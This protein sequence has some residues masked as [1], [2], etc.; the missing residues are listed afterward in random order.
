MWTSKATTS[1]R[2]VLRLGGG[3]LALL[4]GCLDQR[5]QANGKDPTTSSNTS[6]TSDSSPTSTTTS[7]P[8][9]VSVS[10]VTVVPGIVAPNTP[11]SVAVFGDRDEQFLI[12]NVAP[13]GQPSPASADF[14]LSTDA[15]T[16]APKDIRDIA[17]HGNPFDRT[18]PYEGAGTGYLLYS[19]SNPLETD[20]VSLRWPGG[21]YEFENDVVSAL[22]R[23]PTDFRVGGLDVPE[24]VES[25]TELTLSVTIENTGSVE[26]TFVGALNRS[27]PYVAHTPVKAISID[28]APGES[29][30]WTH[31][32]TP[33][34]DDPEHAGGMQY[35]FDW[36]DGSKS[37]E[38]SVEP[39]S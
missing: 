37:V 22:T 20:S 33:T 19:L 3:T 13:S 4:A 25:G 15:G 23:P 26:G 28:L 11:D 17:S 30:T 38:L 36:R 21:E 32:Y 5:K 1:R 27:G 35:Y 14:T 9:D 12:L 2:D 29:E 39:P 7:E 8:V 31:T 24:S 10:N 6:D 16:T 34:L 18:N